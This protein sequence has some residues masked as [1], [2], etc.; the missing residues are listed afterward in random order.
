MHSIFTKAA[1]LFGRSRV[2]P[3]S[4]PDQISRFFKQSARRVLDKTVPIEEETVPGYRAEEF[5]PASIGVVLGAKY[6]VVAKLG[7][8]RFSTVWLGKDIRRY[9]HKRSEESHTNSIIDGGGSHPA[10]MP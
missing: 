2:S 7:F 9:V 5:Y 6:K 3:S 4:A 1:T 10:S 8:G